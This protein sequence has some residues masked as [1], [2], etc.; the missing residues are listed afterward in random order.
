MSISNSKKSFS[1]INNS[2]ISLLSSK[3][4][5]Y[6]GTSL[7]IAIQIFFVLISINEKLINNNIIRSI[8]KNN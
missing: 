1:F 7:L 5:F 3:F 6:S 2:I 8:L 4:L